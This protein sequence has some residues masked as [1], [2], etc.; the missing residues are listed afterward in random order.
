M[1]AALIDMG[2]DINTCDDS[3]KRTPL[4]NAAHYSNLE[5]ARLLLN[6]KANPN[7]LDYEKKSPLYLAQEKD[8]Q[9]QETIAIIKLL[10]PVTKT[11]LWF[12]ITPEIM[13]RRA[14]KAN[15]EREVRSVLEREEKP[16]VSKKEETKE[17]TK[18]TKKRAKKFTVGNIEELMNAW[19]NALNKKSVYEILGLDR[20]SSEEEIN[21]AYMDWTRS[22]H[23][24]VY[25]DE[26][27]NKQA[28]TVLQYL[29][30]HLR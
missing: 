13:L 2:A 4:H 26:V 22:H 12:V 27:L 30:R 10:E 18:H 24:D 14:V 25:R 5:A 11:S 17:S 28:N 8:K 15:E 9:S 6:R 3:L 23:P 19:E 21:E 7:A 20:G 29:N 1:L 16:P